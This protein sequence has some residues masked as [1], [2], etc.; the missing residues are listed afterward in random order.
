MNRIK[1]DIETYQKKYNITERSW[2]LFWNAYDSIIEDCYDYAEEL[3][4]HEKINLFPEEL[5]VEYISRSDN[6][7]YINVFIRILNREHKFI[8]FYEIFYDIFGNYT[9]DFFSFE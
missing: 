7:E 9:D 6:S 1:Y 8:G 2:N 4:I 3:G 5:S